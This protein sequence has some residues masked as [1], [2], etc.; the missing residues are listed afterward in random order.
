[1]QNENIIRN[2]SNILNKFFKK[3]TICNKFLGYYYVF[4]HYIIIILS[5]IIILFN[6]NPF[7]LTLLLI[8]LSLD[9]FSIVVLHNCPLTILERKYLKHSL[10]KNRMKSLKKSRIMYNCNHLYETQIELLINVWMLIACKIL[11]I[12]SI[13][14][15]NVNKI[16]ELSN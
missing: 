9:A 4:L 13:K 11:F 12:L 7:H 5:S 1:M 2:I 15:I 10:A 16:L 8:L 6:N 14:T 3:Y